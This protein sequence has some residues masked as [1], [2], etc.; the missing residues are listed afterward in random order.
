MGQGQAACLPS[1]CLAWAN[2]S[3]RG[4]RSRAVGRERRFSRRFQDDER[5]RLQEGENDTERSLRRGR[6]NIRKGTLISPKTRTFDAEYELTTRSLGSGMSGHVLLA[7]VR[8]E[9]GAFVAVKTLDKT[10]LTARQLQNVRREVD[11]YMQMDH[12]HIAKLLRVFDESNRICLVMEH[13]AGGSL[14]ERLQQRGRF[15]ARSSSDAIRQVLNAV[16]YCHSR[17]TGTVCHRDLKLANFVYA[18]EGEVLKLLDFGLSRVLAPGGQP[19]QH[20]AGTL[21][22]MAPEVILRKGHTESCDMWSVGVMTCCLLTGKKPFHGS[23]E[24]EVMGA[25]MRGRLEMGSEEWSGVSELAKDFVRKLI[26]LCPAERLTASVALRH[27]WL[28]NKAGRPAEIVVAEDVSEEVL[29]SVRDFALESPANRAATA[30]IVYADGLPAGEEVERV[31]AQ[32]RKLDTDGN[33]TLSPAELTGPLQSALGV[34][35]EEGQ[36]IFDS[37]D[38]VKDC[39][40]ERSEF[41]A[42]AACRKLLHSDAAIRKAFNRL[43]LDGNGTISLAEL[44]AVLGR[45]F[46]GAPAMQI[47]QEWDSDGHE[48]ISYDQFKAVLRKKRRSATTPSG[49][50]NL[51][52]SKSGPC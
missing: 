45:R 11:I 34:S 22:F 6:V 38:L 5:A 20:T 9:P 31:E 12:L 23:T 47:F 18:D 7:S 42:A 46:C 4:R 24:V 16:S 14:A 50:G 26:R 27:P 21:D 48:A 39:E 10:G 29:Q 36:R 49:F 32:F 43:D 3:P 1:A 51:P 17:P 41:L 52:H 30:M 13:C 2:G 28:A 44:T 40:I 25:V 19:L 37:I 15:S 33:G 35:R 8:E